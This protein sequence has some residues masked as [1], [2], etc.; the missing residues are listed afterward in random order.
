MFV[1]AALLVI[2]LVLFFGCNSS[3]L[4]F[5]TNLTHLYM[6]IWLYI[7]TLLV[8]NILIVLNVKGALSCAIIFPFHFLINRALGHNSRLKSATEKK[9]D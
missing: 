1:R 3:Y 2:L 4:I 7:A 9:H 5:L 6:F 8:I